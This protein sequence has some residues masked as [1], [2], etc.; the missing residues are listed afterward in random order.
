[1]GRV[2]GPVRGSGPEEEEGRVKE[3]DEK[4]GGLLEGCKRVGLFQIAQNLELEA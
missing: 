2:R 4:E 1:M 3:E